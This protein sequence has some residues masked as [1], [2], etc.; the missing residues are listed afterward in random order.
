[1]PKRHPSL[2]KD[3]PRFK[4]AHLQAL[5]DDLVFDKD[6]V[7]DVLFFYM[8]SGLEFKDVEKGKLVATPDEFARLRDGL[9]AVVNAPAVLHA[10]PKTLEALGLFDDSEGEGKAPACMLSDTEAN[11]VV[12]SLSFTKPRW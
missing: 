9:A 4:D 6:G 10:L 5:G 12:H 7:D 1:M 8:G 3:G 11:S 2:V